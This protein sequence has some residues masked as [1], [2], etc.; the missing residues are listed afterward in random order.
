M[1]TP[2]HFKFYPDAYMGGTLGFTLEQHG[3]Y[4]ILLLQQ[5]YQGPFTEATATMLVG[6]NNWRVLSE[7]FLQMAADNDGY[8]RYGNA[9]LEQE[10]NRAKS[11]KETP[12]KFKKPD[13]EA[14]A[15]CLAELG[16]ATTIALEQAVLFY[17]HYESKGWLIGRAPM[18]SWRA[19]CVTWS[20]NYEKFNHKNNAY[21]KQR[22]N[23]T[24]IWLRNEE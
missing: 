20:R 21:G 4:L 22:K 5:Y 16:L 14:I 10:M 3:A 6:E 17:N 13:I 23:V 2:T 15:T 9:R 12:P 11:D 19:A 8:T 24:P 7:K 1:R 18:K